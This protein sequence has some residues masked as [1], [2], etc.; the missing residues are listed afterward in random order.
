MTRNVG[1][2]RDRHP[3]ERQELAKRVTARLSGLRPFVPEL[4]PEPEGQP[5]PNPVDDKLRKDFDKLAET[6][7]RKDKYPRFDC[8]GHAPMNYCYACRQE[9]GRRHR[10]ELDH[11]AELRRESRARKRD[12]KQ[13]ECEFC[14]EVFFGRRA[15]TKFCSD[16][17]RQRAHRGQAFDIGPPPSDPQPLG[18]R[19]Q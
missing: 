18:Y 2:P 19:R 17:C 6:L 12:A 5:G 4:E 15:D 16:T 7:A 11:A 14:G 9:Y 8:F 10:I 13:G 3:P 1:G